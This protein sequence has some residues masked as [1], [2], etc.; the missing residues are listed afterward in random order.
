MRARTHTHASQMTKKKVNVMVIVFCYRLA[1]FRQVA[2][3]QQCQWMDAYAHVC[4][5]V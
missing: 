3:S 1:K 4:T 5:Y 2:F